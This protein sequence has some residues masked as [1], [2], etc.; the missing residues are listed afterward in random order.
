MIWQNAY[1]AAMCSKFLCPLPGAKLMLN[2]EFERRSDTDLCKVNEE[3]MIE[4]LHLKYSTLHPSFYILSQS[5]SS[6]TF[7]RKKKPHSE[8]YQLCTIHIHIKILNMYGKNPK[9]FSFF[10]FTN[11]SLLV[12]AFTSRKWLARSKT[13]FLQ[14]MKH[15]YFWFNQN[16]SAQLIFQHHISPTWYFH[17]ICII[18]IGLKHWIKS[19]GKDTLHKV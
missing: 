14:G 7:W 2:L 18:P 16:I 19:N 15:W 5:F 9:N 6:V 4:M 1:F 8:T 17:V 12:T 13:N 3:K 10:F 11:K